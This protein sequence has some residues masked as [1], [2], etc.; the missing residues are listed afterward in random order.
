MALVNLSPEIDSIVVNLHN[1]NGNS[2]ISMEAN[3][4]SKILGVTLLTMDDFYGY[5]S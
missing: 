2:C 1:W 4:F 5:I 3:K